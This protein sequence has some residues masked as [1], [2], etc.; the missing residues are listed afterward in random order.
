MFLHI[1]PENPQ[2]RLIKQVVGS[3]QKG[4]SSYTQLIQCMDWVVK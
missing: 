1:Q 2:P 4:R 3:L